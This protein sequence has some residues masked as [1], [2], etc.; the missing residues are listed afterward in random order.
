MGVQDST[1]MS[2]TGWAAGVMHVLNIGTQMVGLSLLA[3][4]GTL[5]G[6][7]GRGGYAHFCGRGDP[8]IRVGLQSAH[9]QAL[10][11][12]LAGMEEL[13]GAGE[14]AG[15]PI[16]G[17]RVASLAGSSYRLER[18]R[19]CPSPSHHAAGNSRTVRTK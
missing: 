8:R 4:L 19:E 18:D 7:V 12:L 14:P 15:D 1:D 5:A 11:Q 16:P 17:F 10:G 9:L 6:L 3:A 13:L 2:P